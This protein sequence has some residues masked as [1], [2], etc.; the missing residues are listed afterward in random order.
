[1]AIFKIEKNKLNPIS[2]KKVNLERDVQKITE[3]NLETIFGLKFVSSEYSKDSF[4]IDTIAFNPE[5]R[6]FVII[7]YKKDRSLSVID[8]GYAYLALM[9]NNKA[10]FILEYNE[11][12]KDNL[13]RDDVDWSQSKIVFISNSFTIYQL[14]AINFR[15]L[16]IELWE[17]KKYEKGIILY[18]QLKSPDSNESIKTITKNKTIELV[19]R[20]VK[21]YTTDDHFRSDWQE[22]RTLFEKIRQSILDQDDRIKEKINKY[23]IG[24][25]IGFYNLCAIHAFKSKLR[26]DL[27]RVDRSELKDPEHKLIRVPWE[28][29]GWGKSTSFTINNEE[30]IVYGIYL[31]KQTYEKFY[32]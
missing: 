31:I 7:E 10:D 1:M 2:E 28:K 4:R 18:S 22:S 32:K 5:S 6:S 12:M 3:E 24:Y 26:L 11:K 20:E 8:Q 15:D 27:V 9:L 13:K 25:K 23:Y 30:D 29:F 21:N 16:P 19:S 14:N 17:L